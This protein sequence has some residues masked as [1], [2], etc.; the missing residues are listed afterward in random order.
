MHIQEFFA[1]T[2]DELEELGIEP[3]AIRKKLHLAIQSECTIAA[4]RPSNMSE[5]EMNMRKI[6][7]KILPHLRV[8][9]ERRRICR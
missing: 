6:L 8:R 5:A 4:E 7:C 9:R 2:M 1:L 3:M